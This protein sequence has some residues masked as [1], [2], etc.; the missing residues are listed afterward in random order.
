MATEKTVATVKPTREKAQPA[1]APPQRSGDAGL[2]RAMKYL[3]EV[4]TELKKT[5]L[6]VT[7]DP[8]AAQCAQLVRRL[9]KGQ[10]APDPSQGPFR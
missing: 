8:A 2:Q 6:M 9:D 7:H 5:I 1:A 3:R 4:N 10:L